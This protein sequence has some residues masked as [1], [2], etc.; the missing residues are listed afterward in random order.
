[1][2]LHILK[3]I[4]TQRR[5]NTWV[6]IELLVVFVLLWYA[7][8]RM[9]MNRI[10]QAQP[11]EYSFENVYKVTLAVRPSSSASFIAYEK[12]SQG[13]GED[14]MRIIRQLEAH[15]DVQVVGMANEAS[16]PYTYM[17]NSDTYFQEKD[18]LF[19]NALDFNVTPGY[20]RVF[21]IHT[22]DGG[23][24]DELAAAIQEGILI[25][26][27]MAME[28]FGSAKVDGQELL[29]LQDDT[30]RFRVKGVTGGVKREEFSQ[31]PSIV[32]KEMKERSILRMGEQELGKMQICFRVRPNVAAE[33]ASEYAVRFKKEMKH[34][35]AA[36]N[37][38]LANVQ[39]YPD[40]RTNYLATSMNTSGQKLDVAINLFLLINVFLAVIGT[41]W[42][43]VNRRR[44][45]LGIRMAV[46]STRLRLQQLLIGEG[47]MILT[48][49][50]VPAL[51][52]CV[53]VAFA[54]L[55]STE[56]MEVTVGRLLLVSLLTWLLLAV[57]IT[58]AVWYPSRKA[59]H[60]EPAEALH[61]E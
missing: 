19:R 31:P 33:S 24:S 14:F 37:F 16:M 40:L 1:M 13:A 53:N 49:T 3:L 52:I 44:N 34:R 59:A 57:I 46:G 2:L 54:G 11:M 36:G 58:L 25:S 17:S 29:I 38:W 47:L 35:L 39:Y 7:V 56:V 41:F 8:D 4:K 10:T 26:E 22:A 12:G 28:C 61:Y 32:F 51:L 30:L 21:D 43:R 45:E 20:F 27:P 50:A 23:S 42:F 18:S 6:F 5:S 60:L 55:L 15:P 9:M 48:I